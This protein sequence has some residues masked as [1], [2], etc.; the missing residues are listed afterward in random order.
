MGQMQEMM[1]AQ[2]VKYQEAMNRMQKENNVE[3]ERL[4][5]ER[6]EFKERMNVLRQQSM[7]KDKMIKILSTQVYELK[8]ERKKLKTA[9]DRID[10]LEQQISD[11][12]KDKK[13]LLAQYNADKKELRE[14][15]RT[16][17][18]ELLSLQKNELYKKQ[19]END[20]MKLK[21]DKKI[22][23]L[24]KLKAKNNELSMAVTEPPASS[25]YC[26]SFFSTKK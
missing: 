3:I 10:A 12:N 19:K 26:Y 11:S 16:Q 13:I 18:N 4:N 23:E 22:K 24:K 15:Y 25:G 14:Q 2:N 9:Y 1:D 21:L 6:N 17:Q 8:A 5:K 7:E 20:A